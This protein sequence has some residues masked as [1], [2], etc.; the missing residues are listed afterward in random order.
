MLTGKPIKELQLI[1][2]RLIPLLRQNITQDTVKQFL[3][4]KQSYMIDRPPERRREFTWTTVSDRYVKWQAD[5]VYLSQYLKRQLGWVTDA[6]FSYLLTII[7]S[8]SKFAFVVP[9]ET[10]EGKEVAWHL[11]KLFARRY[12]VEGLTRFRPR[13]LLNDAGAEFENKFVNFVFKLYRVYQITSP[14]QRPLG[15]IERA[16]ASK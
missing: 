7:D 10:R 13:L 15:I 8:F 14:S 4:T 1:G 2:S 16:T 3:Q 11:A 5:T 12:P 6:P 9:L